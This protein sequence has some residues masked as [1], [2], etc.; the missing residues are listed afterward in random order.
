MD[1]I[2]SLGFDCNVFIKRKVNMKNSSDPSLCYVRFFLII[3][4]IMAVLQ[5]LIIL[6]NL[7]LKRGNII[8]DILI[9]LVWLV[10]AIWAS[11]TF[12][13]NKKTK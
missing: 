9:L 12:R 13:K 8:G 1:S 5:L 10:V 2:R 3:A 4:R 11:I 7:F 6:I